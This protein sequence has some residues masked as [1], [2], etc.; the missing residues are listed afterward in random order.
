M[1][2]IVQKYGGTSVAD[3][4]KIKRVAQRI[5]EA[6]LKGYA[7]VAVLSAMGH[8]TDELLAMA[9][10]IHDS[11]PSR[12]LD[13]L[14][15]TGEQVSVA[16]LAMATQRLGHPA[17]AMTGFQGGIATDGNHSRARIQRIDTRK[18]RRHLHRGS[19]VIV[20]G[21]QGMTDDGEITTL[22]RGGSDITAVALAAALGATECDIFT[23]VA[24]VYTADPVLVPEARPLEY[25]SYAEM[26]ELA[27]AGAQVLHNRSV[28]IA[29]KYGVPMRVRSSFSTQGGTTILATERL[30]EVVVTGVAVDENIA[31]VRIAGLP[32]AVGCLAAL[33]EALAAANIN[34]KLI[35]RGLGSHGKVNVTFI[36][37]RD[38]LQRVIAVLQPLRE[39]LGMDAIE[40]NVDVAK[41][42]IVGSG[43][44]GTPGTAS[45]MFRALANH[46]IRIYG[47]STSEIKIA[48]I[49]EGRRAQDA[50]RALHR[51]FHLEKL[52]R[53]KRRE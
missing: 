49:V 41:V 15:A 1:K 39:P 48:C 12:E 26:L 37:A 44:A 11:P 38:D 21:F 5:A 47:V 22:G 13:L 17:V 27:S 31:E 45:R 32:D 50:A 28:E 19:V 30:E 35:I 29:L 20:A 46:G 2:I 25:I 42:S 51:E 9:R 4:E 8:T 10:Q 52:E 43:I 36:V 3:L 34:V 53:R 24:G 23:D 6:K 33:F 16:L 40:Q 18:I 14:L 7:V